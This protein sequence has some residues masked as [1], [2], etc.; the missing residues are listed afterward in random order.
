[1]EPTH[2]VVDLTDADENDIEDLSS[3]VVPK[4]EA[5]PANENDQPKDEEDQSKELNKEYGHRMRI[6]RLPESCVLIMERKSYTTGVNGL[7]Y[8]GTR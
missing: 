3:E 5:V 2:N 7:C 6:R 1:M 8:K 4:V